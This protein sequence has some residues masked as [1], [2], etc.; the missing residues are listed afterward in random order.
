MPTVI[1]VYVVVQI[2]TQFEISNQFD[3]YFPLSQSMVM[4]IR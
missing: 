4:S 3:F 2:F 1:T